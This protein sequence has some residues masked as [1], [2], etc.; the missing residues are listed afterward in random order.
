KVPVYAGLAPVN[1]ALLSLI[2]ASLMSTFSFAY[3]MGFITDPW[4]VTGIP[5]KTCSGRDC[6]AVFLPGGLESVYLEPQ[7]ERDHANFFNQQQ[8]DDFTSVLVYDAPGYQVEFSPIESNYTFN[9]ED[10]KTY[11]ETAGDGFYI[12]FA[13]RGPDLLAGEQTY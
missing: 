9:P 13:T 11:G 7:E 6:S 1:P 4:V 5:P 8:S 12:C 3:S 10:C 2:P